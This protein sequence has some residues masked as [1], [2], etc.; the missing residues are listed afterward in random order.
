[1]PGRHGQLLTLSIAEKK[2]QLPIGRIVDIRG[3]NVELAGKF[4]DKS[5]G[6]FELAIGRRNFLGVANDA[7]PDRCAAA[8]P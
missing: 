3:G 8:V 2:L 5:G 4:L 1:M 6:A 7:Y